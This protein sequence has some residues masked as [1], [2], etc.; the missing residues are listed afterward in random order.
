M[1]PL[2]SAPGVKPALVESKSEVSEKCLIEKSA[3]NSDS[4]RYLRD[5]FPN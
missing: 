5:R 4:S 1:G 2:G 3:E